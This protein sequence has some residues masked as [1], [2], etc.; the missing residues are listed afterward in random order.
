[1]NSSTHPNGAPN[2]PSPRNSNYVTDSKADL[3]SME[4]SEAR[5]QVTVI[6]ERAHAR[7]LARTN[8]RTYARNQYHARRNL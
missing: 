3:V 4:L 1:M 2:Y 5:G 6:T 8:A 7:T